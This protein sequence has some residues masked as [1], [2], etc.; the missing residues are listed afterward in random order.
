MAASRLGLQRARWARGQ[1]CAR[2]DG[3]ATRRSV[4][5]QRGRDSETGAPLSDGHGSEAEE[6]IESTTLRAITFWPQAVAGGRS[7]SLR[8]TAPKLRSVGCR[9][10]TYAT[11]GWERE[12]ETRAEGKRRCCGDG[13]QKV[14]TLDKASDGVRQALRYRRASESFSGLRS[15]ICFHSPQRGRTPRSQRP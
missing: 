1:R 5:L 13:P 2:G 10:A 12:A 14:G 9:H 3:W 15:L 4:P 6:F 8:V 7:Y 11:A